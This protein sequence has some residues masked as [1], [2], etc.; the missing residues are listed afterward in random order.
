MQTSCAKTLQAPTIGFS[1]KGKP[2][3]L[4]NAFFASSAR[5]NTT[6]AWPRSRYVRRDTT[7][8]MLPN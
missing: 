1:M 7:S 5:S 6:Q 2:C 3:M 8:K 4:S